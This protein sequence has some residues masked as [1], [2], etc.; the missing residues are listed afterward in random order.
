V[1]LEIVRPNNGRVARRLV[2]IKLAD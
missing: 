2:R 1:S